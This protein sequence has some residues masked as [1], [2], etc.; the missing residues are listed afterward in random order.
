M[1]SYFVECGHYSFEEDEVIY[2]KKE[3][4][5]FDDCM[6]FV[7][8]AQNTIINSQIYYTSF[9]QITY[10]NGDEKYDWEYLKNRNCNK[11]EIMNFEEGIENSV[12]PPSIP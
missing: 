3:Y 11:Y 12:Q 10:V 9:N 4:D 1:G 2:K 7:R 5:T 8:L 6:R